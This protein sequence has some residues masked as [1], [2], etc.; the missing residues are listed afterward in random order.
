LV[1]VLILGGTPAE[2]TEEAR[3]RAPAPLV[4]DAATLPFTRVTEIALP[5]APRTILIEGIERAFPDNQTRGT[6][7]VLTQSTYLLQTWLDALGSDDGIVATADR[8]ALEQC[9]P[10]ALRQRGPWRRFEFESDA[11]RGSGLGAS[12]PPSTSDARPQAP[13]PL[14]NAA[15]PEAPAPSP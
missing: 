13:S 4:L 5:P 15:S 11:S 6:R 10:E 7:L 3:R 1:H 12:R 14:S 8:A 9:A 2:R